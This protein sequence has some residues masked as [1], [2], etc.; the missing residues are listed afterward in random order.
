MKGP[1]ESAL[2]DISTLGEFGLIDRITKDFPLFSPEVVKGI[3]DDAAIVNESEN[4]VQV[5]STDLLLEGTHFDLA[6][7]PLRHLGYKAIAVNLSDIA[8]MNARPYG[9][10]VSIAISNRF[11][12]EA[13]DELYEGVKLACEKYQVDLIGGDTSSSR[14]GLVISVTAFGRGLKSDIVYRNGAK[15]KDLICVSGDVGAAYAGLLVLD[16]EKSVY[17]NSPDMQPDLTDYDYV[18]GRQLKPEPQIRIIDQ[19]K[20]LGVQPTSMIDVSDGIASELHHICEQSN[21]G[22]TIYAGKL[23]IDYQT[24]KVA[25][26]FKISPTTFAL[27]GGEDY[28]LLFTLP[29]QDFDKIK[30]IREFTIIGHI[31]E[32][33]GQ[34]QV[35][36]DSGEAV[37]A[38]ALGWNHFKNS[39]K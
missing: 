28:E 19:L 36:L 18:V 11:P 14:L 30:N 32:E 27:N 29:I 8:A 31:T 1:N 34:I 2:T 10:T 9:V 24:V 38:D 20:A 37:E 33:K 39:E 3:G 15:P 35:V 23:P 26:E 21:C 12:I 13:V 22:A 4:T 25:E 5:F 7:V 16:R 6:Y 17:L